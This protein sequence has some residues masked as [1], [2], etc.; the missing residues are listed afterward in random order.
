M[1]ARRGVWGAYLGVGSMRK[2]WI[3]SCASVA[4]I[5]AA[6]TALANENLDQMSKNPKNWVM[7]GGNYA[8][9]NYSALKQINAQNAKDL[10]PEWTFSTGVLR[11]HESGPLVIGDVMYLVTP[12]PNIV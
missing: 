11:G 10:R 4:A 3:L 8:L 5:F 2:I 9:W 1:R 6:N 12:Y 7:Q